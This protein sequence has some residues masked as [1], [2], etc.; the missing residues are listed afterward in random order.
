[1]LLNQEK[2]PGGPYSGLSV[3]EGDL[4]ESW[5]GTFMQACS[6]RTRVSGFKLEEGRFRLDTRKKL[7][8]MRVVRRWN[9]FPTVVMDA[10][11]LEEFRA[12]LDGAV[13]SLL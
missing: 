8:T 4:Q 10:P 13:S 7:F 9:R 1:V 6:D 3:L 5:G 2:V 12:R 11:S